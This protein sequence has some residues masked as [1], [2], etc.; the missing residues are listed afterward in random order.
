METLRQRLLSL[1]D[2]KYQKFHSDLCPGIENI[3]GIRTPV[4]R[5]LAAEIVKSGDWRAYL[6]KALHRPFIYSEEATLCG[7]VIGLLKTDF[8]EIL[9]YLQLFVPR[10]DSW[11]ICDVTCAGLKVFKKHQAAGRSFLDQYLASANE[12]ELRFAIIMLMAYYHDDSYID[13][14]L[15]VLNST[16][17]EG[18]YVKMA[19][20]WALQLCFVK[21]RDKTLILFQHNNLDD[22][23]LNK[24]LQKCR[25][26]FRVSAADK[27]LL[28]SLKR[29]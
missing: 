10:I 6:Q 3:I 5:Q 26:S 21:Q 16:S 20:A 4:L 13:D 2:E 27:E 9:G 7:M 29:K 23:T 11:S 22:F 24:A 28:Q 1:Q 14:T 19:V 8:D 25:E 17:H 18:Y 15:Q 12:Y